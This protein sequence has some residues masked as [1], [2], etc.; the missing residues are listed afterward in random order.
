MPV[1]WSGR[2]ALS[3]GRARSAIV[4]QYIIFGL[5][6]AGEGDVERSLSGAFRLRLLSGQATDR[7]G[8]YRDSRRA[9]APDRRRKRGLGRLLTRLQGGERGEFHRKNRGSRGLLTRG[10][11]EQCGQM[12]Y[13][14][15]N[16]LRDSWR[17]GLGGRSSLCQ[18]D[19]SH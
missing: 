2:S 15:G 16:L 18:H 9:V 4:A 6:R 7:V 10:Q 13:A 11:I 3:S 12:G 8:G 1:G 14:L 5:L 17:H 19:D